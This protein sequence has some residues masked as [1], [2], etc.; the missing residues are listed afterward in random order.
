MQLVAYVRVSRVGGREGERFI[1]PG[2]QRR[3]IEAWAATHG[4]R[5]I[6]WHQD[7]DEPGTRRDRPGLAGAMG[8]VEVG[9][10]G[11][12][13]ARL[14]RFGRSVPHLGA[15]VEQMGAQ[16]AALFTVAPVEEVEAVTC[17]GPLCEACGEYVKDCSCPPDSITLTL[18]REEAE[19][20]LHWYHVAREEGLD[21][22]PLSDEAAAKLRAALGSS[23]E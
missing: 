2:E 5:I 7:L 12:V 13:V 17:P 14:D 11:V 3:A 10:E 19:E 18:T 8:D 1:S 15:L 21:I 16:G 6:A 4:H 20:A 22:P 9:A 23:D